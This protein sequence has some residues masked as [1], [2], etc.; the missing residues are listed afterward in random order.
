[1]IRLTPQRRFQVSNRAAI[2]TALLLIFSSFSGLSNN[3]DFD[4]KYMDNP[5]T[6]VAQ[7]DEN[8]EMPAPNDRK[9]NISLL[10]FGRG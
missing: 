5:E 9:V 8:A 7:S 6:A 3:Q 4:Q 1:M 10:L 2:F